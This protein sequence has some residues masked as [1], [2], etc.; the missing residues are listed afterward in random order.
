MTYKELRKQNNEKHKKLSKISDYKMS[1]ISR[2]IRTLDIGSYQSELLRQNVLDTMLKAESENKKPESIMGNDYK[3]YVN[4]LFLNL[5]QATPGE[6]QVDFLRV[7]VPAVILL[8]LLKVLYELATMIFIGKTTVSL[9]DPITVNLGDFGILA[10][11]I[12]IVLTVLNFIADPSK[13]DSARSNS[14]FIRVASY[15]SFTGAIFFFLGL[16]AFLFFKEAFTLN[17]PIIAAVLVPA[18]AYVAF[19]FLEKNLSSKSEGYKVDNL[20]RNHDD[21]PDSNDKGKVRPEVKPTAYK[22]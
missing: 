6:L 13:K 1:D 14:F 11:I 18:I 2:Y 5:P 3:K 12:G 10:I 15:L 17:I 20:D 22:K 21:I 9:M 7:I 19:I 16:T 4:N 8:V